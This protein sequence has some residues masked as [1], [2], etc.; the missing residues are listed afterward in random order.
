V[1]V[2]LFPVLWFAAEPW[3][4]A[5]ALKPGRRVSAALSTRHVRDVVELTNLG[6]V[7]YSMPSRW[8]T[9]WVLV[10]VVLAGNSVKRTAAYPC[11]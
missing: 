4:A 5:P 7:A 2:E 11:G 3:W 10:V 6:T 8:R 9:F 1:M